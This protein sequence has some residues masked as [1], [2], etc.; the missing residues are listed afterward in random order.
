MQSLN[1]HEIL[2]VT[3]WRCPQSVTCLLRSAMAIRIVIG[4]VLIEK[5]GNIS[6][7]N[8]LCRPSRCN[9][10]SGEWEI[11]SGKVLEIYL[12][13]VLTVIKKYCHSQRNG[14]SRSY[15]Q[16]QRAT[17][18]HHP[19][20]DNGVHGMA[21]IQKSR[22]KSPRP[23]ALHFSHW[24]TIR[25]SWR[26]PLYFRGWLTKAGPFYSSLTGRSIGLYSSTIWDHM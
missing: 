24:P 18:C 14:N 20:A 19:S 5:K 12:R 13:L 3:Y 1:S 6:L 22:M 8:S 17:Q 15:D 21:Y 16:S 11:L 23:L 2:L 9:M 26:C 4:S 10:Y 25:W 7:R